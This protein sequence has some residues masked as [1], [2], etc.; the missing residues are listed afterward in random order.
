LENQFANAGVTATLDS[1]RRDIRVVFFMALS[2]ARL[3]LPPSSR[4]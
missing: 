2:L 1:S 4:T 3:F